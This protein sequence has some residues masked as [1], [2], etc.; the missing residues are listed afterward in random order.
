MSGAKH[1]LTC[2]HQ[3]GDIFSL[4]QLV[5][6][7]A[8]LAVISA[9]PAPAPL[10]VPGPAPAPVPRASVV[11]LYSYPSALTYNTYASPYYTGYVSPYSYGY[12]NL[13]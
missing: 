9:A 5:L 2:S 13:G 6:L 4:F 10:P 7:A 3:H 12:S 1:P 8:V 11:P